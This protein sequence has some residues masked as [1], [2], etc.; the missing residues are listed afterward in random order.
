MGIGVI[1]IGNFAF[2]DCSSLSSVTIGRSVTSIGVLAFDRCSS[3]TEIVIPEGVTFIGS[4][5]FSA[6]GNLQKIYCTPT[7]PPTLESNSIFSG[8]HTDAIIYVPEESV[9]SYKSAGDWSDYVGK[10]VG[11]AF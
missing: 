1:G 11:Y 5:A 2:S 9:D 6:C 7:I 8:I 3:L 10:I 4:S